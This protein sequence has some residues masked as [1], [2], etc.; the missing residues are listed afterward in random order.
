MYLLHQF[1]VDRLV[2]AEIASTAKLVF[3]LGLSLAWW[4]VGTGLFADY[5]QRFNLLLCYLFN[6]R[7][8]IVCLIMIQ[9]F[10]WYFY[11]NIWEPLD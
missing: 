5:L 10:W 2:R 8:W 1:R 7:I 4:V 9:P 11:F 3:A 6:Y